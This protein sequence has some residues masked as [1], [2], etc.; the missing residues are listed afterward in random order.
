MARATPSWQPQEQGFKE[1]YDLLEQQILHSSFADKAQIWQH[2]QH[3]SHLP[4]F[5]NYL[6]FIFSHAVMSDNGEEAGENCPVPHLNERILSSLSRRSVVAHPWHDLEIGV[7]LLVQWLQV[8]EITKG[9]KVMYE[10]D[11]KT[12]L[13]KRCNWTNLTGLVCITSGAGL[14]QLW[15]A[16]VMG[17]LSGSIPWVESHRRFRIIRSWDQDGY[18]VAEVEWLQDI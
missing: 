12:G 4:D 10:L 11:Q 17:I 6:A 2:L 18:R 7:F 1:I 14:M 9:S 15:V 3:Y 16:I 8:V 13:I 5:N